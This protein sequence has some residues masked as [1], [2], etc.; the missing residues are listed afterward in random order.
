MIMTVTVLPGFPDAR[1]GAGLRTEGTGAARRP[2][3]QTGRLGQ[4]E[5]QFWWQKLS[6]KL[7]ILVW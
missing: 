2:D 7:F 4:E 1:D 5:G 6:N 3:R